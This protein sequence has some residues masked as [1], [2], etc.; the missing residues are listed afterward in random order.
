MFLPRLATVHVR[1]QD[2][3]LPK[4]I[5]GMIGN[6]LASIRIKSN[7]STVKTQVPVLIGISQFVWRQP[8]MVNRVC[9]QDLPLRYNDRF[10]A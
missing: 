7:D 6:D 9:R 1:S 5:T 2:A 3:H 10:R 8:F 4:R